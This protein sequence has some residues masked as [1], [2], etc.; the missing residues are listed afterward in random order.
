MLSN[1]LR[2]NQDKTEFIWFGTRQQLAKRD[3]QSI[4]AISP[5]L[6]STSLVRDLGALLDSELTMEKHVTKICQL[7]FFQLRRLRAV[8]H[9]LTRTALLTLVNAF[10]SSRIDY[11][12]S[13]L[14]GTSNY[15]LDR[16]QYVMNA[17]ARLILNLSKYDHISAA[18]RNEL[19]WLPIPR[20]IDFKICLLV[21]NCLTGSAPPYLAEFCKPVSS[22]DGRCNL[23]SASRGDLVVSRFH[24]ERSGRRSFSV[25]G[26]SLWNSLPLEVR[27]LKTGLDEFKR[28]LKTFNAAVV[29]APL[30]FQNNRVRLTSV[31]LLLLTI[32]R[33]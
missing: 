26:P 7:C 17:A 1:R 4:S 30:M 32:K 16:L 23:R 19:H 13:I 33:C 27:D 5:S 3:L 18:I 12:N 14:Y 28:R 11:C 9:S 8:R 20:R 6:I 21:R 15:I 22:K 31:L 24:L 25:A 2:L 10:V 29:M